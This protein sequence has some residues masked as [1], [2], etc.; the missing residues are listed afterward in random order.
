MVG[1]FVA[2][3]TF[4]L[5]LKLDGIAE[6]G[7]WNLVQSLTIVNLEYESSQARLKEVKE[8]KTQ[9]EAFVIH[10]FLDVHNLVLP[11]APQNT[12]WQCLGTLKVGQYRGQAHSAGKNHNLCMLALRA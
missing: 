12:L 2:V 11:A 9:Q 1:D 10:S 6:Q 8:E 7:I 4:L 5:V 3:Q